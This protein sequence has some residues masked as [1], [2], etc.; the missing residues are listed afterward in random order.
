MWVFADEVNG[1]I[2]N[3]WWIWIAVQRCG[4]KVVKAEIE[5]REDEGS[6]AQYEQWNV[7]MRGEIML[8][9]L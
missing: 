2:H 6:N 8:W 5:E 3:N 7:E 1:A 4:V 9:L